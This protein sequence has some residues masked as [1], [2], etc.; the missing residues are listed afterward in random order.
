M[1][2]IPADVPD[3]VADLLQRIAAKNTTAWKG[4]LRRYG[5]PVSTTVCSFRLQE[6]DALDA[7]QM[8]WLRLAE[9]CSSCGIS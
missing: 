3:S 8:T 5:R 7:V 6:A 2:S 1:S 4:I 9:K